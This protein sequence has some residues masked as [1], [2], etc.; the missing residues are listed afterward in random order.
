MIDWHSHILPALDDGS[1]NAEESLALLNTLKNQ[2]INTVIAT[3][4]FYANDGSV[5]EFLEKRRESYGILKENLNDSHPKILLGAE[6]KYY[7][8]ISKLRDL[9][10]LRIENSKL[11]LLEMPFSKWT[12]YTVKELVEMSSFSGVTVVIAH[13][14]R[15]FGFQ[16]GD[17]LERLYD[18]GILMQVNAGYFASPLTRKRAIRELMSG[19]IHFIGSDC[20]NMTS[21]AP[22]MDKAFQFICKKVGSEILSQLNEQGYGL[23]D[24]INI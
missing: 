14:E 24:E 9:K 21:R 15:Y 2:G 7:Q 4:H 3:P 5:D 1:R 10:A 20:H 23:L 16:S 12:E 11:L 19:Q 8:G 17:A 22:Q 18:S 6:V 13:T